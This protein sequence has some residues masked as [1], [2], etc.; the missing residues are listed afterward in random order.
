VPAYV[1]A[2]DHPGVRA[3]QDALRAVYRGREPLLVR[4]GGTLP[5]AAMFEQVLGLK[6]LLFSFS[7]ADENL[8]APNEFFRL[9][10]LHEGVA[11]WSELWRRLGT[12]SL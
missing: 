1:I 11:A 4:I 10:R 6:T 8:H 7:T 3:A 9:T 2:V 12:S 5:A